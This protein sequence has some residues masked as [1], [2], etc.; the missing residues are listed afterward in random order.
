MFHNLGI[1]YGDVFSTNIF[2]DEKQKDVIFCDV[3]NMKVLDYPIDMVNYIAVKFI[4]NYGFIDDK[5]DSYMLNLLTLEQ[6]SP[7]LKDIL[8]ILSS[9]YIPKNL[10]N[11]KNKRLIK[12]I[13]YA[14]KRTN[15]NYSGA[16]LID[17][18]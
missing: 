15:R 2:I 17:N 1:V 4:D 8:D 7:K 5:L 6:F 18:L 14:N 16:Y 13:N 12:K 10:T 9:G 3:D 11:D